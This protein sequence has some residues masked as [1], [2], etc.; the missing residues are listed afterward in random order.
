[1]Y[2]SLAIFGLQSCFLDLTKFFVRYTVGHSNHK[3]QSSTTY[4]HGGHV[5][6][7]CPGEGEGYMP[8]EG[9]LNAQGLNAQEGHV[10]VHVQGK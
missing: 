10:N 5:K 8:G 9:G 1:M 3:T 2:F 4:E 7:T 6:G